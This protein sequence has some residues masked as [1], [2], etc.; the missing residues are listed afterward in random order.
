MSPPD[1][2]AAG[3]TEIRCMIHMQAGG[4]SGGA[5]AGAPAA[6]AYGQFGATVA[7]QLSAAGGPGAPPRP[8]PGATPPLAGAPRVQAGRPPPAAGAGDWSS[9]RR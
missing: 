5:G 7:Q 6:D 2:S 9:Q 3:K 1:S 4:Y 8:P